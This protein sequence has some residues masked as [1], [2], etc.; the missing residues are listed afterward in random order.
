MFSTT[1]PLS[2]RT[3]VYPKLFSIVPTARSSSGLCL[4]HKDGSM[5]RYDLKATAQRGTFCPFNIDLYE[6]R[7]WIAVLVRTC[8]MSGFAH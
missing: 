4:D 1:L 7:R 6:T 2:I 3:A 5:L 8:P